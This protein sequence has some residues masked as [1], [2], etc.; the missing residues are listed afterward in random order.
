MV[1]LPPRYS[2]DSDD[3]KFRILSAKEKVG[4]VFGG[5]ISKKILITK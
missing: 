4:L 1:C 2:G 5:V 3:V